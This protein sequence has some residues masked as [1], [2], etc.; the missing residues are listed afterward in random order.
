MK[1]SDRF[2]PEFTR[3]TVKHPPKVMVWGCFSWRGR[4]GLE[5]LKQGEMMN[6]ER[7]RRLLDE[8]L[9]FFLTQHGTSHFLQ[10]GAPCHR[11]K[12]VTEWF[13]ERPH[14]LRINW[15]GNSPDLNPIK[16]VWSWMKVQLKDVSCTNIEM[17]KEEIK[18]LWI[19]ITRMADSQYLRNLA[20]SMPRCLQEVIAREGG[21]TK[22]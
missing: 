11:A 18:K 7:Y 12:I 14:I 19:S 1:G 2:A 21:L 16:N 3:K 6:G 10:D 20:D 13:R 9:E 8:K 22:Y 15:P 17:L 4:G 5:F